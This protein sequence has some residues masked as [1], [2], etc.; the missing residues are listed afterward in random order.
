MRCRIGQGLATDA[1]A[2]PT[3]GSCTDCRD[4]VDLL[5]S[6]A[7]EE[8]SFD[9]D[10]KASACVVA[11]PDDAFRILFNL[12]HN[13]VAVAQRRQKCLKSLV[14]RTEF[15]RSMTTMKLADDGPGLP[16]E[17]RGRLFGTPPRRRSSTRHG[18]GLAIA[19][20]LA[21]RNCG[22]LSVA[23][24]HHGTTFTLQLPSFYAGQR[25]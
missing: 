7:P 9:I 3:R 20:G 4:A 10:H 1:S 17:I 6:L 18:Y 5:A 21:E 2:A 15:G 14:I 13:A 16:L 23:T 12:M 24:S 8:F 11:A 25:A 22:M 19:R